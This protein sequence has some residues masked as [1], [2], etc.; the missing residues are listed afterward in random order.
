MAYKHFVD[1]V[2]TVIT[3]DCGCDITGATG[4]ALKVKKPDGTEVSWT[5]TIYD[6]NYLRYTTVSGDL[7]Q[8]GVY[9]VQSYLTIGGWTGR[10]ETAEF[11]I[12]DKYE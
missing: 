8:V 4:T 5:A 6:S 2:G 12:Y 11:I 7:D 1:E 3:V 10:G 9:Y